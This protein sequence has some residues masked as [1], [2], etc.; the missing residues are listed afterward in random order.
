[1]I[2]RSTPVSERSFSG[3]VTAA[4]RAGG[5]FDPITVILKRT[6][7]GVDSGAYH[8]AEPEPRQ[9]SY[10]SGYRTNRSI[11]SREENCGRSS[12]LPIVDDRGILSIV[13]V[14]TIACLNHPTCCKEHSIY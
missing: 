4:I 13:V 5:R 8:Y 7:Q 9:N 1:M 11:A 6:E 3:A 2:A 12:L 14:S 10:A